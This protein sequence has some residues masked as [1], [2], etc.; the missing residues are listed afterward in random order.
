MS[1]GTHLM[2]RHVEP[3]RKELQRIPL[4]TRKERMQLLGIVCIVFVGVFAA[5]GALMYLG[6]QSQEYREQNW[7]SAVATIEDTRTQLVGETS[8]QSG[9]AMLYDVQVLA[10]FTISGSPQKR[11]ITIDQS[12]N[13][14]DY[15]KFQGRLWMGKKYF[16]RWKPFDPNQI[17]ID[18]H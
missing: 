17:V 11:W 16:V 4:Q 5:A 13:N 9:G 18:L 15:A 2:P 3:K 14:L 1:A 8:G 10:A 12:P 6:R 7:D